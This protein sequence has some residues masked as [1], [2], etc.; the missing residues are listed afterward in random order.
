MCA[1]G[2]GRLLVSGQ[3]AQVGEIGQTDREPSRSLAGLVD[4][5]RSESLPVSCWRHLA[6]QLSRCGPL[7]RVRRDPGGGSGSSDLAQA[8]SSRA[9]AGDTVETGS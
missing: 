1:A 5:V 9:T 8:G 7:W 3:R 6:F 4:D 2:C